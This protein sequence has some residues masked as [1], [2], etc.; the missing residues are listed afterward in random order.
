MRDL[1]DA[2]AR[3][4]A[5]LSFRM[6]NLLRKRG[7]AQKSV[8]FQVT[9]T[10]GRTIQLVAITLHLPRGEAASFVPRADPDPDGKSW[11]IDI[12]RNDGVRR[13]SYADG[14]R[15][16]LSDKGYVLWHNDKVLSDEQLEEIFE[17]LSR[18]GPSGVGL[19]IRK[20][21]ALRFGRMSMEVSAHLE[22]IHDATALDELHAAMLRVANQADAEAAVLSSPTS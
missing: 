12:R 8:V 1:H 4:S 11:A 13:R 22:A 17:D 19:W 14:L 3:L 2:I 10:P 20:V 21:W 16:A 6:E 18:P 15:V 5:L 9:P 7:W